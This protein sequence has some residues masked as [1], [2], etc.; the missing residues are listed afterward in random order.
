MAPTLCAIKYGIEPYRP[1]GESCSYSNT[2]RLYSRKGSDSIPSPV[3]M[4]DVLDQS[5]AV[6]QG[7]VNTSRQLRFD[8]NAPAV[9]FSDRL[10]ACSG[11]PY[12]SL[13]PGKLTSKPMACGPFGFESLCDLNVSSNSP[14]SSPSCKDKEV[15]AV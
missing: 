2:S 15:P 3:D 11:M 1:K 4:T 10:V 12:T 6:M 13:A 5:R 9:A 7:F 14:V 8:G